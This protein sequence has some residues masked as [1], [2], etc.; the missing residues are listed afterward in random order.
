LIKFNDFIFNK[1]K[2]NI[3]NTPTLPSLTFAIF[4]SNFLKNIEKSGFYIPLINGKMYDDIKLSY[5]GGST[6]M[7]IPTNPEGTLVFCNDV[8]S[9]YPTNMSKDMMMPVISK[10]KKRNI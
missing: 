6:D 7:Y 9:L 10:K 5:T 8:N 3:H 2:L 1:F 4:R